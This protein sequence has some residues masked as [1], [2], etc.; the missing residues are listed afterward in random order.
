MLMLR[1]QGRLET[2]PSPQLKRE[3]GIAMPPAFVPDRST[4]ALSTF[5]SRSCPLQGQ[6]GGEENA[7]C[8]AAVLPPASQCSPLPRR[9]PCPLARVPSASS[10]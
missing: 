5:A 6:G 7:S 3:H 1:F 4:A 2:L 8:T 9:A 10:R